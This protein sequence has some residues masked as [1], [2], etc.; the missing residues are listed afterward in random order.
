MFLSLTLIAER[1]HL[2][3][4]MIMVHESTHRKYQDIMFYPEFPEQISQPFSP[5]IL[6]LSSGFPPSWPTGTQP[7]DFICIVKREEFQQAEKSVK[8]LPCSCLLL[9]TCLS[10]EGIFNEIHSR[11][12]FLR[13]QIDIFKMAVYTQQSLQKLIEMIFDIMGNPAYLVDSSF[14][15]LAIDR[16]HDMRDLSAAW[17]RLEDEGYLPFDLVSSLIN[18]GELSSMETQERAVVVNSRYF[19][20]PFINYNLKQYG[21]IKGHLFIAGMKK[22]IRKSDIE[23]AEYLGS[24]VL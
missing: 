3:S 6:Y 21:K 2:P 12:L 11:I 23:L 1:I 16:S 24:Y 20:V 5:D 4:D 19:Y 7:P 14:K 18:S 17:R 10:M 22:T 13:K 15:V 8:Q 9:G